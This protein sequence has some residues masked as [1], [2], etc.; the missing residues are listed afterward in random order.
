MDPDETHWAIA[1]NG[2]RPRCRHH[3]TSAAEQVVLPWNENGNGGRPYYTC[4]A[5]NGFI[6]FGDMRGIRDE[7]PA[8][9]CESISLSRRGTDYNGHVFYNCALGQCGFFA[10][11]DHT[12]EVL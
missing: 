12:I 3:H 8:C 7:N 1:R 10:R 4:R 9:D 6:C 11:E 2:F 5:C